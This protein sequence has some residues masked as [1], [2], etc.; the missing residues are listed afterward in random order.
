MKKD[1]Y[2]LQ[3]ARGLAA[4]IV[5]LGHLTPPYINKY[6]PNTQLGVSI[7]FC[8][9]GF[10]MVHTFK[11][12][13]GFFSFM[14]KRIAR[15]YPSYIIISL[16]MIVFF[17]IQAE[18]IS[19]ALHSAFFIPWLDWANHPLSQKTRYSIANPI[20]WT[21]FYEFY[22]YLIFSISKSIFPH[23]K[24]K[25]VGCTSL[26]I[27]S[28]IA[29]TISIYGFDHNPGF[30]AVDFKAIFGNLCLLPF[31]FGMIGSLICKSEYKSSKAIFLIIPASTIMLKL[32]HNFT[33]NEQLIDI[34]FSG[35][36][37]SVLLIYLANAKRYSGFVYEK[38]YSVG[39]YSYSLYLFHANLYLVSG[40][41]SDKFQ[42][43]TLLQISMS[44]A[45]IAISVVVSKWLYFNLES[46]F[47]FKKNNKINIDSAIS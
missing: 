43:N 6:L 17:S 7:F 42:L 29:L 39:F 2:N 9:S 41:L 44:I 23:S 21:L 37:C 30:L 1:I 31:I 8:L 10:I 3:I 12:G 40:K 27:L 32:A 5:V 33:D 47:T 28:V 15:I 22:F 26:V 20:A 34:I 18:S 4:L 24:F 36:P 35:I 16:P 38:L 11:E 25:V 45:F 13:D 19:Y 14:K 46:K